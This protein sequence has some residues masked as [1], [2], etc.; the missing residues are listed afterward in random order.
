MDNPGGRPEKKASLESWLGGRAP[1]VPQA[2]LPH[3]LGDG[4]MCPPDSEALMESGLRAIREALAS[5]GRNRESAYRL[6]AGDALLTYACEAAVEEEDPGPRLKHLL[7]RLG[8][9]FR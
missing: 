5:P 4:G 7:D 2:F 3:L 8:D 1:A 9:G 6:L